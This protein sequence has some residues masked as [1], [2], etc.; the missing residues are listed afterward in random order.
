[1]ILPVQVQ[2]MIGSYQKTRAEAGKG[3]T[4]HD[5]RIYQKIVCKTSND[6]PQKEN[7]AHDKI[8]YIVLH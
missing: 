2:G 7:D 5:T 6:E 8:S 1:M 3:T 4:K